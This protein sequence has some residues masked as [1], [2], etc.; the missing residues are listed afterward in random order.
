MLLEGLGESVGI[1]KHLITI[2][3]GAFGRRNVQNSSAYWA[4]LFDAQWLGHVL[5]LLVTDTPKTPL[6]YTVRLRGLQV[7]G[8]SCHSQK[9]RHGI[10]TLSG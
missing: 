10:S 4:V 1:F 9:S 2:N 7:L 6:F 8:F 3:I 5:R